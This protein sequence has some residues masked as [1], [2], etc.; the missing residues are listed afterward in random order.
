MKCGGRFCPTPVARE[1]SAVHRMWPHSVSQDASA[2]WAGSDKES[3]C[4]CETTV[5]GVR[6]LLEVAGDELISHCATSQIAKGAAACKYR[7]RTCDVCILSFSVAG[8]M[9]I[10][11][12]AH[13]LHLARASVA[14]SNERLPAFEPTT[15]LRDTLL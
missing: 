5:S 6:R 11:H 4:C 9:K 15:A 3:P 1:A 2:T 8:K 12:R 14:W 10:L 13:V 7:V